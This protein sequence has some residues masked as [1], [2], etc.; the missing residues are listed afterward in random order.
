MNFKYMPE[1]DFRWSYGI[2]WAVIAAV[3]TGM[4]AF[5]KRKKWF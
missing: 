5:F 1:L 3:A 2:F 4:I